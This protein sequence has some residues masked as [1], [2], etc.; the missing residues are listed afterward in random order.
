MERLLQIPLGDNRK[1]CL[2]R[3]LGPY[4]L[5]VRKLT[6][7]QATDIMDE[8]LDKCDKVRKLEFR[9]RYNINSVIRGNKGY[10]SISFTKLK[11]ENDGL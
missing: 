6:P 8:W 7:E 2:W 5:N 9:S 4:L 11:K 10:L 1:Y 3:I